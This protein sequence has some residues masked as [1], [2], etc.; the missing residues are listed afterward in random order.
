MDT[1]FANDYRT[2]SLST[3][4]VADAYLWECTSANSSKVSIASNTSKTTN[5]TF[6]LPGE[7]TFR[8]GA[9]CTSDGGYTYS[10]TVTVNV[11]YPEIGISGPFYDGGW[12]H[13]KAGT[14]GKFSRSGLVYTKDFTVNTF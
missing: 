4:Q 2:A 9:K 11:P 6:D 12:N 13:E 14:D 1:R 3:N 5:A 10:E 8:V 7:Y